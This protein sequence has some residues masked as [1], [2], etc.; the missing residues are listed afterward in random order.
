MR[1]WNLWRKVFA[2]CR[3]QRQ[4]FTML[5]L[6]DH[7]TPRGLLPS[8]SKHSVTTAKAQ[9]WERLVNGLL[10]KAA[11]EA[12]FDH[13]LTTDG[14][15]R[16]QQNLSDRGIAILVLTDCTKWTQVRLHLDRISAAVDAVAPGSYTAVQIPY[17]A[18]RA[19]P[20]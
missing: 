18:G 1:Y 4:L 7:G 11:E 19:L 9:G 15:M 5:I 3:R 16:Y 8:L 6:F 17:P 14:K 12:G 13:L 10:L 20:Y 2:M